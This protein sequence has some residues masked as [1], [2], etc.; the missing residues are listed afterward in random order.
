[1]NQNEQRFIDRFFQAAEIDSLL[2]KLP[3]RTHYPQGP[4]DEQHGQEDD[5]LVLRDLPIEEEW[6][7]HG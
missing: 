5:A 3:S 7:T 4:R 6:T 1:M 2:G